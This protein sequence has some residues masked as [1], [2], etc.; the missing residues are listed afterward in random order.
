[1]VDTVTK[2]KISTELTKPLAPPPPAVPPPLAGLGSF[3]NYVLSNQCT[4]ITGLVVTIDVTQ[5]II[6]RSSAN[7][8]DYNGFTFQLN[9]YSPP[10]FTDA[11][12][13]Y[14]FSLLNPVFPRFGSA[15][16]SACI[17]NW[18]ATG[19]S[20]INEY[21]TVPHGNVRHHDLRRRSA[22]ARATMEFTA[23]VNA[24]FVSLSQIC[25]RHKSYVSERL[26]KRSFQPSV[27]AA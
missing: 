25:S 12:Q 7:A 26:Y 22:P 8:D 18:P 6:L 3:S 17:N 23:V 2:T 21:V 4:H 27:H 16:L 13:Q 24:M 5:D 20:L 19:N 10:D 1:M 11:W 9:C 14:I 15:Q